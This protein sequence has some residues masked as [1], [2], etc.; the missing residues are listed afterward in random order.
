[1]AYL[2]HSQPIWEF[3]QMSN[4][5]WY[6]FNRCSVRRLAKYGSESDHMGVSQ[7]GEPLLVFV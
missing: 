4:P 3:L 5:F 7:N 1:M 6:L 2:D